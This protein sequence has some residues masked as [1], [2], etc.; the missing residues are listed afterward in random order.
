[1]AMARAA[2]FAEVEFESVLAHR[3][4]VTCRRKWSTPPGPDAAPEIICVENSIT[5]DH[6]FST[7][8]DDYM[9]IYFRSGMADLRCHDVFV[10]IGP[11][12]VRPGEVVDSGGGGWLAVCKLPP[13]LGAQWHQVRLRVRFSQW[14][15]VLRIPVDVPHLD[16]DAPEDAA[17][18]VNL[19][20]DGK[21]WDRGRVKTGA[22]SSLSLWS[23]GIPDTCVMKDV[24]VLLNGLNLPAIYVSKADPDGQKQVNAT[25]PAGLA[26]GKYKLRL[27][28]G[29]QTSAPVDVELFK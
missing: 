9:S 14:S 19:V 12:A 5:R 10:E 6:D 26:P 2:G 23:S 20:T 3:G 1:M 15:N 8:R 21:T 16:P 4:H 25:L 22:N 13:G 29:G 18:Q 17:L 27:E 7:N 11:Y 24:L 28:C